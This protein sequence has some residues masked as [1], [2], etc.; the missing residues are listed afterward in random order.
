[1]GPPQSRREMQIQ[2]ARRSCFPPNQ[3][4]T[5]SKSQVIPSCWKALRVGPTNGHWDGGGG[6]GAVWVQRR[7]NHGPWPSVQ[8]AAPWC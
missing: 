6:Q 2:A 7:P 8:E 5:K 3:M 4:G 1:M